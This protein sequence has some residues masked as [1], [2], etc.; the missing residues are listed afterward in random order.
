MCEYLY[1][2]TV[3]VKV[4]IKLSS[5]FCTLPLLGMGFASFI[6]N[7]VTANQKKIFFNQITVENF[8]PIHQDWA[9][10]Q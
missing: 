5:S 1:S 3:F 10:A 9:E 7:I 2:L 6:N 4:I 8:E